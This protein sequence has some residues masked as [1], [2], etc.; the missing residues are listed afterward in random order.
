MLNQG[1]TVSHTATGWYVV[2]GVDRKGCWRYRMFRFR[3]EAEA[4]AAAE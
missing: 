1:L 3:A 2:A 4:F